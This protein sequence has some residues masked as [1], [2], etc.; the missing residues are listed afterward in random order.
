MTTNQIELQASLRAVE[1]AI[2]ESQQHVHEGN[3]AR[4]FWENRGHVY[5]LTMTHIDVPYAQYTVGADCC[6]LIHTEISEAVE[7]LRKLQHPIDSTAKDSFGGEMADAVIRIMDLCAFFGI[8][9][10]TA[11]RERVMHNE[12]RSH[13]HGGKVA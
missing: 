10:G 2:N 1:L 13:M 5:G 3:K 6:A 9:L 12:T 8:P 7:A 4:G 11:I